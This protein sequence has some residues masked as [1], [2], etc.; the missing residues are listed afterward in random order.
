MRTQ[1]KYK[2][3]AFFSHIIYGSQILNIEKH[4]CGNNPY[5]SS[6][7]GDIFFDHFL[8][9]FWDVVWIKSSMIF[10]KKKQSCN[11]CM[12]GVNCLRGFLLLDSLI[13]SSCTFHHGAQIWPWPRCKWSKPFKAFKGGNKKRS[14][15]NFNTAA[16]A[17]IKSVR[18]APLGLGSV[19]PAIPPKASEGHA[20]KWSDV[21]RYGLVTRNVKWIDDHSGDLEMDRWPRLYIQFDRQTSYKFGFL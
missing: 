16:T 17:W 6:I 12:S 8:Y 5:L 18:T 15:A 1:K 7:W 4:S 10:A 2:T 3:I 14:P 11:K 21:V 13:R 20:P 19:P 9:E